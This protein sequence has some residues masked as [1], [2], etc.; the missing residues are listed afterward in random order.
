MFLCRSGLEMQKS[1]D[2]CEIQGCREGHSQFSVT[3]A[4]DMRRV[5]R[6]CAQEMIAL[7]GWTL[8]DVL[9]SAALPLP[10]PPVS[11]SG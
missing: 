6:R 1:Q 5:C 2:A 11:S 7:Y 9:D 4:D 3:K 10:S 8:I